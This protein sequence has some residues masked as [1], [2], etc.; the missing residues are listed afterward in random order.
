VS[1]SESLVKLRR[2]VMRSLM[3][4]SL[5]FYLALSLTAAPVRADDAE[6]KAAEDKAVAAIK[7]ICTSAACL[8]GECGLVTRDEKAA[9]KPVIEVNL[10]IATGWKGT[11]ETDAA[12]AEL[13]KLKSLR[14][15]DVSSSG[16]TDEGLMALAGLKDFG[17][18]R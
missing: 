14:T 3:D 8:A 15:L 9:G 4:L 12:L 7:K 10:S 13:K 6:D 16:A 18:T 5:V 17:S 11:A 2:S 1:H